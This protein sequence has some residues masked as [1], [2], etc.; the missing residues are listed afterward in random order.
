MITVNSRNCYAHPPRIS[1][2]C[3]SIRATS[4]RRHAE[5]AP[6]FAAVRGYI[7]ATSLRRHAEFAPDFAA[8]RLHPGYG[9]VF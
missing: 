3:G 7:R 4:L 5:F 2:L 1:P 8:V 9:G 6:D